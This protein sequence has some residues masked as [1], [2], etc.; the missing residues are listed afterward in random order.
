VKLI[1]VYPEDYRE[2][3]RPARYQPLS[4]RFERSIA[5]R[6][7]RR[8][9]VRHRPTR[10]RSHPFEKGDRIMIQIQSTWF[11]LHDANPQTFVENI[12]RPDIQLPESDA[13]GLSFGALP[14]ISGW[15][16]GRSRPSSAFI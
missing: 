4:P 15:R 7:W 11:P 10:Q 8:Y 3:L 14:A 9:A 1:D 13:D 16:I 12:R 6:T 2:S 5:N